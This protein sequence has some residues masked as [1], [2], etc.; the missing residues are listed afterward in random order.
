[1]DESP[2]HVLDKRLTLDRS[3]WLKVWDEDV[4]LPDGR[5]IHDWVRLEMP[6]YVLIFAVTVDGTVPFF[7]HYKHGIG[8]VLLDPPGGYVNPSEDPL[9]AAQRELLEET[10]MKAERWTPL[11]AFVVD[12]NREA[13]WGHLFLAQGARKVAEPDADDLEAYETILCP[14]DEVRTVWRSGQVQHAAASSLI[15]LSL[16]ELGAWQ[17]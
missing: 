13:G 4:Q 17:R 6:R 7:R 16:D 9:V 3:P 8:R 10:G 15:A 14:L 11:A 2:W 1:M 12:S 5:V